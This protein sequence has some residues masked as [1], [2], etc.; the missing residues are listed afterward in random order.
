[1]LGFT[2]GR[3][4]VQYGAQEAG[5]QGSVNCPRRGKW[6]DLGT[7]LTWYL[8]KEARPVAL[9][10]A[11]GAHGADEGHERLEVGNALVVLVGHAGGVKG[12]VT[13]LG[14]KVQTMIHD[15]PD[16]SRPNELSVLS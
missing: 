12:K 3:G 8:L 1:M 2:S 9:A 7:T 13:M 6:F 11:I 4:D 15:K 16:V 5:G 14:R 10:H